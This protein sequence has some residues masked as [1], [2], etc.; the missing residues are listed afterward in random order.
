MVEKEEIEGKR[1]GRRDGKE[2]ERVKGQERS[3]R[4]EWAGKKGKGRR[5]RK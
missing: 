2:G 3:G 4:G 1:Q 5:Y